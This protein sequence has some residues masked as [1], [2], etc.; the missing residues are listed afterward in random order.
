MNAGYE[1]RPALRTLCSL[2]LASLIKLSLATMAGEMELKLSPRGIN[3]SLTV[4]CGRKCVRC[5]NLVGQT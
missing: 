3:I 5:G 4:A 2:A 1:I